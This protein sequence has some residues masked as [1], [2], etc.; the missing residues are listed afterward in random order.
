MGAIPINPLP[1]IARNAAAKH[2]WA[3]EN[4]PTSKRW[5]VKGCSG[6]NSCSELGSET[7]EILK[8][9]RVTLIYSTRVKNLFTKSTQ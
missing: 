6:V 4:C 2:A 1:D 7:E 8:A 5:A 3:T 9:L